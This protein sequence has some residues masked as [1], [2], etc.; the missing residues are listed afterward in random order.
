MRISLYENYGPAKA[1]IK[2]EVTGQ[3][4]DSYT[5]RCQGRNLLVHKCL[6]R[7]P[8][9]TDYFNEDENSVPGDSFADYS[10]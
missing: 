10:R 7:S 2:Y 3:G 9:E 1:G 6:V 5:I 4:V 8:F